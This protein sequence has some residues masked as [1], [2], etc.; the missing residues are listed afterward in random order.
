MTR[1]PL[2]DAQLAGGLRSYLPGATGDLHERINAEITTTPQERR[3]PSALGR[4][5]DADPIARR[6]TLL[7]VAAMALAGAVSATAI[8]GAMLR[9]PR[10]RDQTVTPEV[11]ATATPDVKATPEVREVIRGWPGTGP[12]PCGSVLLGRGPML[13][14]VLR[15]GLHA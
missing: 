3:L 4:L 1:R 15:H 7:L 13:A 12:N 5:T 9:E 11:Q 2:T 10:D 8:A 14:G 6:R